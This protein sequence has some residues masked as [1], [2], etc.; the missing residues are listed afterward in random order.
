[1]NEQ[2]RKDFPTTSN[3]VLAARYGVTINVVRS[4]GRDL[5]LKKDP[6]YR[7]EVQR[8]NATGR[9]ISDEV[10]ALLS[11]QKIGKMWSEERKRRHKELIEGKA[12]RG[13]DHYNWK[14]G[15]AWKR[16]EA[17]D[18]FGWRMRVLTRD[19]FC[20][21]ECGFVGGPKGRGLH[22]HHVQ[23][24]VDHPELRYELSNGVTLCKACHRAL[25]SK[26]VPTEPI[27]CACGCGTVIPPVDVHKKRPRRFVNGHGNRGVKR[28]ATMKAAD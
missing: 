6:E 15:R 25:H 9:V 19:G 12:K 21:Q 23:G 5:G 27:P 14:G 28:S 2:F 17:G 20:C 3:A 26:T 16:A 22:A 1:M 24:F 8:K 13:P 7:R 18:Y 10:K 4:R 11:E